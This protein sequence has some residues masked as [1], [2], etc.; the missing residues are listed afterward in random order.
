M[1]VLEPGLRELDLD[2]IAE[3]LG[4]EIEGRHT[5]LGDALVTAEIYLRLLPR[6][7]DA[8]VTTLGEARDFAAKAGRLRGLQ[9]SAG[10]NH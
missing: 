10:W 1:A 5:A 7:M 8:G 2:V 3:R 6:L 9:S 4:V